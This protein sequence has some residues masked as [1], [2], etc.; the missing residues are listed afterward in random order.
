MT[1]DR[2]PLNS[3][4]RKRRERESWKQSGGSYKE[5]KF[6]QAGLDLLEKGKE[7]EGLSYNWEFIDYLLKRYKRKLRQ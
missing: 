1:L 7:N 4:Q 3:A 2:M 6:T 5:I